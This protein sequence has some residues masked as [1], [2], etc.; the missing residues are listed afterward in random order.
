MHV[1]DV[2]VCA[3]GELSAS[4]PMMSRSKPIIL[5]PT[6]QNFGPSVVTATK[7]WTATRTYD[8]LRCL[9]Q[10]SKDVQVLLSSSVVVPHIQGPG[11]NCC[12]GSCFQYF[13]YAVVTATACADVKETTT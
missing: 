13:G 1:A 4:R 8:D 3:C 10:G 7:C 9:L 6:F 5:E 12:A 11:S 2:N